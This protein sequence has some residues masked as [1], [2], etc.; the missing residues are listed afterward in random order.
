MLLNVKTGATCSYEKFFQELK[1]EEQ[2]QLYAF[3]HYKTRF[4]VEKRIST[5]VE[6]KIE[7]EENN[8]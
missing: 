6:I 2:A 5:V 7:R 1:V 4:H 3:L 8:L